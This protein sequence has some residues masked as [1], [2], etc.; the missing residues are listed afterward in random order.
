[1]GALLKAGD[2]SSKAKLDII[3]VQ[4]ILLADYLHQKPR[5]RKV[6]VKCTV[7]LIKV[8]RLFWAAFGVPRSTSLLEQAV[9]DECGEGRLMMRGVRFRCYF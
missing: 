7:V 2:V 5:K 8:R 6:I 3:I 1:M 9:D 4:Q